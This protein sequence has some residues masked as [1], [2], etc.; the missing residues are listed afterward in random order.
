MYLTTERGIEDIVAQDLKLSFNVD[1]KLLGFRGKVFTQGDEDLIFMLNFAARSINRVV[2]LLAKCEVGA[3]TEIRDI[4]NDIDW[5]LYINR[6][7]T[8]A[9][10]AERV[11]KHNFTSMDIAREVG[12]TVIENCERSYKEKLKVNLK[13]P[14]VII[15]AELINSK[16]LLGIDTTGASL[17]MRRY[18]VY[19]HPMPLRTTIAYLLVRLSNWEGS[20]ILLDP[21]CGGGTIPIEASLYARKIPIVNFRKSE[22]A[23]YKLRFLDLEKASKI[24]NKLLN[25]AQWNLKLNVY[26]MDIN[27]KHIKGAKMNAKSAGVDDTITFFHGD[28]RRLSEYFPDE[29][30]DAIISN[31][32]YKLPDKDKLSRL[33]HKF[34]ININKKLRSG[35]RAVII[36]SEI[37]LMRRK[38]KENK[39]RYK[40]RIVF[41]YGSLYAGIFII[42]K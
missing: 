17:H 25:D 16:F 12:A 39:I 15:I 31:P 36:T 37:G 10:R 2:I 21:M 38:L 27:K 28:A 6:K 32:P 9:V 41:R 1:A 42:S 13:K 30:I 22:Y 3:L 14:D 18:R 19:N 33:Y 24:Q 5:S 4:V 7:Q 11:G 8:F 34:L 35:G 26:G 40:E 20:G 29:S 23:F